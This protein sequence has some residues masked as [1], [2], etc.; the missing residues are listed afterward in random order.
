[1]IVHGNDGIEGL[2]LCGGAGQ[3]LGGRE[4]GLVEFNGVPAVVLAAG[5]LA[6]IC[7]KVHISANR[8]LDAYTALGLGP[9]HRDDREGYQGPLAGLESAGSAAHGAYLLLLPCDMPRLSGEVPAKLL[10]PLRDD[11]TLQLTYARG[12][13]RD[14]FLCAALRRPALQ[15][16]TAFLD[17]GGRAVRHWYATLRH[18]AVDFDAPLNAGLRNFNSPEDWAPQ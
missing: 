2:V 4:K 14:H 3:R 18:R 17:E 6:P 13:G 11:P 9:V 15:G 8:H 16:L 1:M 5:I 12:N 7:N 10:A